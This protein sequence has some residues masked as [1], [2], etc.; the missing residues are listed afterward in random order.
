MQFGVFSFVTSFASIYNLST[1]DVEHTLLPRLFEHFTLFLSTLFIIYPLWPSRFKTPVITS[2][3]WYLSVLYI[4]IIFSS[5]QAIAANFNS[6]S[7]VLFAIN[8]L[9]VSMLIRWQLAVPLSILGI[10]TAGIIGYYNPSYQ[11]YYSEMIGG[12]QM[13]ILYALVV[14]TSVL[15][16]FIKPRQDRDDLL[17]NLANSLEQK[18][19]AM[20]EEARKALEVKVDF[21]NNMNH[22]VRTPVQGVS[23]MAASLVDNWETLSEKER[24]QSI[25]MIDMNAH[26][27]FSLIDG[28]LNFSNLAS[29]KTKMNYSSVILRDL[30]MEALDHCRRYHLKNKQIQFEIALEHPLMRIWCDR[31]YICMVLINLISN[32]IKYSEQGVI[33]ISAKNSFRRDDV[34]G[35]NTNTP[36][37]E[38]SVSDEGIGVPSGEEFSIFLPF[39]LSSNT[40]NKSGGRG[41]G[42]ALSH[43][44]VKQ[45]D[46]SIWVERNKESGKGSVFVFRI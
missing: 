24:Y 9:V 33:K 29:N 6:F 15:I 42:L 44:I 10:T 38:V 36:A 37:V 25:R 45:H 35:M 28:I 13:Q 8:L 4:L 34:T 32:A 7:A 19:A 1:L 14:G 22:E 46:G 16:G 17:Q 20:S 18:A 26:R 27:F 5:M 31:G 11:V 41:V 39:N 40:D 43:L 23:T 12:V 30:V 3:I 2:S 21:I